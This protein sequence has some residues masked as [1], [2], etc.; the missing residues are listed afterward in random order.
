MDQEGTLAAEQILL[1]KAYN[2]MIVCGSSL[3]EKY[4]EKIYSIE[5]KF[6]GIFLG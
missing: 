5:K 6:R 3:G 2:A 1:L 4:T